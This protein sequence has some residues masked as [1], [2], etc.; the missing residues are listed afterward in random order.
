MPW[1]CWA[2]EPLGP[3]CPWQCL[4]VD[5]FCFLLSS[6]NLRSELQLGTDETRISY[7]IM[8][9]NVAV[10]GAPVSLFPSLYFNYEIK[11]G[12]NQV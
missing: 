10:G 1:V 4:D 5:M 9:Y 11:F 8:K 2:F 3:L 12:L 6:Q 7:D